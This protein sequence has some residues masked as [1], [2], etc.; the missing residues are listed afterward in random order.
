MALLFGAQGVSSSLRGMPSY[1]YTLQGGQVMLIPAGTWVIR[2]G[3]YLTIQQ[4]DPVT[5]TWHNIGNTGTRDNFWVD[6]DGNNWRVANQTGCIVGALITAAGTGYPTTTTTCTASAGS[7][8]LTAVVGGA[9]NTVV[10]VTRPGTNYIYPPIVQI[11]TPPS[12]GV[13]ATGY[14]TL[15]GSTVGSITI[16]N[17]GA[18]YL[19]TPAITLMNDPRDTTGSGAAAVGSL[20]GGGTVTAILVNDH[21]NPQ[22]AV[23]TLTITGTGGASAA[24]TAIM[25]FAITSY[26]VTTAGAGYSAAAGQVLVTMSPT[27]TAGAAAYT[28]PDYSTGLTRLRPCVIAATTTAGGGITT[29]QAVIDGGSFQAVPSVNSIQIAPANALVTT[30]AVLSVNVGGVTDQLAI[31][32]V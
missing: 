7:P 6:S 31:I 5:Q 10:T 21:G 17:Q 18:G 12:P 32:P 4:Y 29:T 1:K 24:A 20:T 16:T 28:N 23:P 8:R 13:P 9:L 22:T 15:S 3:L 19:Q 25:N 26:G 30:A 27:A 2:P 14:S 11:A